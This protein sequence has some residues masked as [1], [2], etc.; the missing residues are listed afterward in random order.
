[1]GHVKSL[2]PGV[3]NVGIGDYVAAL[4]VFGGYASD[5]IV[6]AADLVPVPD[7]LPP[8]VAASLVLNGLTAYQMLERCC[9]AGI[10]SIA[11]FGASGGV[12]S[13]LLDLARHKKL[14]TYGFASREKHAAIAAKGAVPLERHDPLQALRAAA[15]NGVDAVFDGVGGSASKQSFAMLNEGGILVLFGAQSIT[16]GGRRNLFRMAQMWFSMPRWSA[17]SIFQSDRGVV[18]YLVTKW[19]QA[20]PAHYRS[21]LRTVFELAASGIVQPLINHVFNLPDA[22]AAHVR[23]DEG[24][25]TG[26]IILRIPN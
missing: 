13:I 6:P 21:D 22:Q 15:P 12:G 3:T 16:Q 11:V 4:T 17:L 20:H 2:G 26:K 9:P 8:E 23:I 1:V 19:K 10:Q 25:H 24:R 18:G 7:S 14:T 5:V